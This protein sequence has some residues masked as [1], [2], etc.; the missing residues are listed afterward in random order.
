VVNI[1]VEP[2][3]QILNKPVMKTVDETTVKIHFDVLQLKK[4]LPLSERELLEEVE[5]IVRHHKKYGKIC[6]V[7]RTGGFMVGDFAV[8]RFY[9]VLIADIEITLY[10]VEKAWSGFDWEVKSFRGLK[11]EKVIKVM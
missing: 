3:P 11:V 1:L 6:A 7:L 5:K 10:D 2:E 4:K 8:D 9:K